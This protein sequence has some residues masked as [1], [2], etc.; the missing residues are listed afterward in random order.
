MSKASV[1]IPKDLRFHIRGR[2]ILEMDAGVSK[3]VDE[4]FTIFEL[5][6]SMLRISAFVVP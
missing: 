4:L 2:I 5:R 3:V 6:S 1:S